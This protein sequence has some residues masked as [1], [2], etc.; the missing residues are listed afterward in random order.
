LRRH[1]APERKIGREEGVF[2]PRPD[3]PVDMRDQ[4]APVLDRLPEPARAYFLERESHLDGLLGLFQTFLLAASIEPLASG[5]TPSG[6]SPM[7]L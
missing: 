2:G 4:F 7:L 1:I 6:F 5:D 3:E